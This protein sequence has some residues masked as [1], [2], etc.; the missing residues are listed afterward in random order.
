MS[1]A[2]IYQLLKLK[3][4]KRKKR[5]L[6]KKVVMRK[7]F[8]KNLR[9][10]ED[11]VHPQACLQKQIYSHKSRFRIKKFRR[12]PKQR[13]KLCSNLEFPKLL[14]A[15][16]RSKFRTIVGRRGMT[17]SLRW[18]NQSIRNLF[19]NKISHLRNQSTLKAFSHNLADFMSQFSSHSLS[20]R[21]KLQATHQTLNSQFSRTRSLS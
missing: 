15:Y 19:H 10:S 2:K 9:S 14:K 20:K 4:M 5:K 8:K 18:H 21:H 3:K 7:R 1:Q 16:K 13:L 12:N 17:G 11:W 6:S